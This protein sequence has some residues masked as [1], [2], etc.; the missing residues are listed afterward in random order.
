MAA[1]LPPPGGKKSQSAE[2]EEAARVYEAVYFQ[3]LYWSVK[4]SNRR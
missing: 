2:V 1:Q 3:R 4:A